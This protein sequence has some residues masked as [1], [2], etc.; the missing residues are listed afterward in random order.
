MEK[1]KR[2]GWASKNKTWNMR[3]LFWCDGVYAVEH[4]CHSSSLNRL[5]FGNVITHVGDLPV[6]VRAVIRSIIVCLYLLLLLFCIR[7]STKEFITSF[8]FAQTSF[9]CMPSKSV[10]HRIEQW[11]HFNIF[12]LQQSTSEI[13]VC[14]RKTYTLQRKTLI[15]FLYFAWQVIIGR[16]LFFFLFSFKKLTRV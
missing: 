3:R 13:F 5:L 11:N 16:R 4:R 1:E 7:S 14:N 10:W 12:F 2:T 6:P 9:V 8:F 15:V